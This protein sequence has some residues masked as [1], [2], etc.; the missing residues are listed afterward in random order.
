MLG[1]TDAIT[2]QDWY[3]GAAQKLDAVQASSSTLYANQL[4]NLVNAMAAF[5]AP[6]G[7]EMNLTQAQRDQLNQI[8]A[9]NWQ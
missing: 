9:V 3:A 5:G 7:G 6:Q 2:V 8:I 1:S 4:D